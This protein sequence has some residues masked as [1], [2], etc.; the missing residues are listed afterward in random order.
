ML[1][2]ILCNT[3]RQAIL[4]DSSRRFRFLLAEQSLY[5]CFASA[6]A[7][8]DQLKKISHLVKKSPL[9]IEIRILPRNSKLTLIPN[10]NFIL[11]DKG[12]VLIDGQYQTI[13]VWYEGQ[14][15]AYATLF[16]DLWAKC[17]SQS[18][19]IRLLRQAIANF[20]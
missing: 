10:V 2:L 16:D 11:C 12:L 5:T 4:K 3:Q 7:H 13:K 19:S 20:S 1:F 8:I 15:D 6:N 9:N 14:I 17:A 18:A